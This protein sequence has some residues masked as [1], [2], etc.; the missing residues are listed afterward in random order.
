VRDKRSM[1]DLG[2]EDLLVV[3]TWDIFR[4]VSPLLGDIVEEEEVADVQEPDSMCK[5]RLRV[6]CRVMRPLLG[7]IVE[8]EEGAD[9]QDSTDRVKA[10]TCVE[11]SGRTST[12]ARKTLKWLVVPEMLRQSRLPMRHYYWPRKRRKKLAILKRR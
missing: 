5:E 9:A 10:I 4:V 2:D 1:E 3:R 8:K 11:R 12:S 7:D 6:R